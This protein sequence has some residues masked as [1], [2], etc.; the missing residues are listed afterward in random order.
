MRVFQEESGPIEFSS[1]MV[2]P[3]DP[4]QETI[5]ANG[6]KQYL[7]RVNG[8]EDQKQLKSLEPTE[9]IHVNDDL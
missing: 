8:D 7:N 2:N 1:I 3:P 4:S 9:I 5:R 6:I